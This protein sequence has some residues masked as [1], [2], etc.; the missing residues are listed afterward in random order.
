MHK[1]IIK[2]I[3]IVCAVLAV[4][5]VKYKERV[6]GDYFISGTKAI[7]EWGITEFME[8]PW[9]SKV[10]YP[11]KVSQWFPFGEL[12]N[13]RPLVKEARIGFTVP[14]EASLNN[15]DENDSEDE[16]LEEDDEITTQ[17]D[18]ELSDSPVME[19]MRRGAE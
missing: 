17:S 7:G 10:I 1:A 15:E 6:L 18:G 19:I 2:Y 8:H 5:Q 12:K 13:R 14:K 9:V 4:G 16:Y 3:L 11:K